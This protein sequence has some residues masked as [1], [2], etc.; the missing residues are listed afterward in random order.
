MLQVEGK[1]FKKLV[2]KREYHTQT[3][4]DTCPVKEQRGLTTAWLT[5]K[6]EKFY[7]ED[8]SLDEE[9]FV[10][11]YGNPLASVNFIRRRVFIE[12]GDDKIAIK[13]QYYQSSRKV[14]SKFFVVRKI[15]K[16]FT[17]SFKTKMFYFGTYTS[18]KK[19]KMGSSMKVNPT[20]YSVESIMDGL[21]ID[22]Q[23]IPESYVFSFLETI[24]DRLGIVDSQ[25]FETNLPES[26]YSLTLYLING[27]KL[28]DSW[29][30]FTGSFISKKELRKAN[31]NLVDAFMNMHNLKGS[32]IKK[33]LNQPEWV[34]FER[35]VI[36]YNLLGVDRFNKLDDCIFKEG[37]YSYLYDNQRPVKGNVQE[38][39]KGGNFWHELHP[40]TQTLYNNMFKILS[41]KEKDRITNLNL[42][43]DNESIHT[44]FDHIEFKN[45]LKKYG[46]NVKMKFNDLKE[47]RTEHE[48]WSRLIDSY[49]KGEI[50]RYYGN[51]D[52]LET[53]IEYEGETY[54][55]I[56]LRKTYDYEKESQHQRN[57]VRTYSERPDCI[58]FSI[59]KGS[60]DGQERITVEYQYRKNEI[61][62]VQER[63]R[64][65]ERPNLTFSEV[66]KIQLANINLVYK[67]GT[68]KLPKMVKKFRN[69][70]TIEQNSTFEME[71]SV[72]GTKI[73]PMTPRWDTHTDE[74]NHWD[75]E[76]VPINHF[77]DF[78]NLLDELP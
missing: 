71:S 13:C 33:L 24:W 74:F 56:L 48:E 59:R 17:F 37:Y 39:R 34:N 31:F 2:E 6:G 51:V 12:E 65:N 23:I 40:E 67:I 53:P 63:G 58:I 20:W 19:Q 62:N 45:K 25:N 8:I 54:Y 15:T 28:P 18:K 64:F 60:V 30:Q 55:P 29:L 57:C 16:F 68:L 44:I 50:E 11:Y 66:A 78:E 26:F 5:N 1:T 35:I 42:A 77:D 14:G 22:K 73:I 46:E 7:P 10:K 38:E 43:L 69:G 41:N 61:L 52:S 32:K 47:L 3:Y 49:R 9:S 70:R 27:V 36:L 21:R 4:M 76:P 72:T 75:Y